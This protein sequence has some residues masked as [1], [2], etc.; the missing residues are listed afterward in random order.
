MQVTDTSND[1]EKKEISFLE[2]KFDPRR[3]MLWL[4]GVFLIA[5]VIIFLYDPLLVWFR[6]MF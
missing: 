6:S 5:A 1:T 3:F 2:I 4:I